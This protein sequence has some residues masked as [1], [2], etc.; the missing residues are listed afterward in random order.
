MEKHVINI[1][2]VPISQEKKTENVY[3]KFAQLGDKHVCEAHMKR[4]FHFSREFGRNCD[5]NHLGMVLGGSAKITLSNGTELTIK[6]GD[7]ISIPAGHDMAVLGDE[8][9]SVIDFAQ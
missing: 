6:K 5:K 8:E 2:S 4:G 3:Y 1:D 9:F 7:L